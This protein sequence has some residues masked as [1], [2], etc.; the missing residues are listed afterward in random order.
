MLYNIAAAH[1]Q[2]REKNMKN[3]VISNEKSKRPENCAFY[4]ENGRIRLIAWN[5][6]PEPGDDLSRAL[7]GYSEAE[8][9]RRILNGEYDDLLNENQA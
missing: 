4:R 8:L 1:V 6:P 9:V 2:R 3:E 5:P 7:T